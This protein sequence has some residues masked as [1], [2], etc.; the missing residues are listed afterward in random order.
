MNQIVRILLISL[1]LSQQ[2]LA[3]DFSRTKSLAE[4][5]KAKSE[6][7]ELEV[8]NTHGDV[9][10]ETWNKKHIDY[11]V[12]ISVKGNDEARVNSFFEGINIE[13]SQNKAHLQLH[14]WL[15]Q[16]KSGFINSIIEEIKSFS[17][18]SSI[19]IQVDYNI[20]VPR[21]VKLDL[22]NTHGYIFLDET[23]TEV[24]IE[25]HHGGLHA[26]CLNGSD[27]KIELS[28][29]DKSDITF[30]EAGNITLMHSNLKIDEG[31][32]LTIE[33]SHSDLELETV[34]NLL[35][36]ISFGELIIN[37]VESIKLNASHAKLGIELVEH[38]LE[39]EN[40]FG[41]LKLK[42]VASD[43][44][45]I[46]IESSHASINLGIDQASDYKLE[47]EVRFAQLH[48][49]EHVEC[50]SCEKD[51]SQ[52]NYLAYYKKESSKRRVKLDSE[53]GDIRLEHVN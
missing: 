20:K 24:D 18:K 8:E 32:Q 47:A 10:I 7:F 12:D 44:Q 21:H 11:T 45:N 17:K 14:T 25:S 27:N 9:R 53:F 46:E 35:L 2:G 36:D 4:S 37:T 13:V 16:K 19:E 43:F 28:H 29:A 40:T 51:K 22:S 49:V 39:M 1:F 5:V 23:D 48:G 33:S 50:I 15:P 31:K 6:H 30:I 52:K 3:Q 41:H 38:S 42:K 26:F 34:Q